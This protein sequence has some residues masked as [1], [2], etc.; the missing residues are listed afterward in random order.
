M[1]KVI[2]LGGGVGG[3]SAAHHLL[4]TGEFEV[5]VYERKLIPGGKARSLYFKPDN[6]FSD[7]GYPAEHGFRFFPGFYR[8]VTNTMENI[9]SFTEGKTVFE[10]LVP[11]TVM[12]LARY[13]FDPAVLPARFPRT[14]KG[15]G[16][17]IKMFF[18][19][20]IRLP[21]D[22]F[23][24]WQERVWQILTSCKERRDR[25][26]EEI[27]WWDFIKAEDFSDTYQ[28][29]LANLTRSLVAAVPKKASTK[30]NGDILVQLLMSMWHFGIGVDRVLD[31][32]TNEVWIH[33]WLKYLLGRGL[34]YHINAEIESIQSDNTE[35]TGI[36]LRPNDD[37]QGIERVL[38][39]DKYGITGKTTVPEEDYSPTGDFYVSAVP[40]ERMKKFVWD[41]AGNTWTNLATL[42]PGLKHI[43][44]LSENTQWMNGLMFYLTT[45]VEILHGHTIYVDAPWA[46][47][48][49]SQAQ[50]WPND[51]TNLSIYGDGQ[52]KGI[53]SVDISDWTENAADVNGEMKT[54]WQCTPSEIK[55]VVWRDLRNSLN[56]QGENPIL[57]DYHHWFLDNDIHVQ[58]TK[59]SPLWTDHRRSFGGIPLPDE[60]QYL[61]VND[62]PLLVNN[63]NTWKL[64]PEAVTDIPNLFLASDYVRTYTDLATMEGAN[65]AARRAVNG[66]LKASGIMHSRCKIWDLQ[67]PA[68]LAAFR[69]YDK[70]R[71]DNNLPWSGSL[72]IPA[73]IV[74]RIWSATSYVIRKIKSTAVYETIIGEE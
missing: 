46:L 58:L 43:V 48:S 72:P 34:K 30:T 24:F 54:A 25:D 59:L 28:K 20:N 51:N 47:T 55:D 33:P 69:W 27:S 63:T 36:T 12:G 26:Y 49:I 18:D 7:P 66:I 40:V 16:L 8:H 32:P 3:L 57:D 6:T 15:F 44:E 38:A 65:E 10:S 53:I 9:P 31:G 61:L 70:H 4:D 11:T 67:E 14:F 64:R 41:E 2:I 5:E 29:Y 56:Q 23:E 62:E 74:D 68:V 50:F 22:E 21:V 60:H 35:I 19:S 45:D 13:D 17:L 1:K 42:D 37:T 39:V 52:L 71:F 73:I